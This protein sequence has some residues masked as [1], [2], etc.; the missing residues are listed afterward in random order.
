M[1]TTEIRRHWMRYVGTDVLA[2]SLMQNTESVT[3]NLCMPEGKRCACL[4]CNMIYSSLVAFPTFLWN[5]WLK[6]IQFTIGPKISHLKLKLFHIN[7]R[8]GGGLHLWFFHSNGTLEFLAILKNQ[9]LYLGAK[10]NRSRF[11]RKRAP[12]LIWEYKTWVKNIKVQFAAE[13]ITETLRFCFTENQLSMLRC[14]CH[15]MRPPLVWLDS[16]S[17]IFRAHRSIFWG[18]HLRR[19]FKQ[20]THNNAFCWYIYENKYWIIFLQ[21][22]KL[23]LRGSLTAWHQR[24]FGAD[25]PVET[26]PKHLQT[27]STSRNEDITWT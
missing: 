20:E 18:R 25:I 22:P 15:V 13:W 3:W 16:Y 6:C 12:F 17:H 10:S 4:F 21:N 24:V 7:P 5:F 19:I 1:P 23:L 11:S 9:L 8:S 27:N 14:M 26:T 2:N